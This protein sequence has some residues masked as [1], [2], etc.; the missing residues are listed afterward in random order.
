M[1]RQIKTRNLLRRKSQAGMTLIETLIALVVLMIVAV[2]VM[3]LAIVAISTTENQGHLSA[4][5]AE[6]AQDKMEQLMALGYGDQISNTTVFP[7]TTSPAGTG[8]SIGGSSNPNAPVAGYVDYLDVSGNLVSSTANWYYIRV[9]Q[10]SAAGSSG[11]LKQ[12]AVTSRVNALVGANSGVLPQ[13]TV[14]ALKSN[15]F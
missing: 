11:Q 14:V 12:I 9:W 13:S 8:L 1:K 6:Y 4:R 2:N 10:V 15:P 3:A 7:T 5:T